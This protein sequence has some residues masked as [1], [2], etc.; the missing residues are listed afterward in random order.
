MIPED[1]SDGL[2][3]QGPVSSIA[4]YTTYVN[5][6]Q[7]L[8][9]KREVLCYDVSCWTTYITHFVGQTRPYEGG[10]PSLTKLL[11]KYDLNTPALL[12]D[13]DLLESNI[14][15][16]ADFF[17]TV[18]PEL[19]PHMKTHKIPIISHMQIDAGAIGIT[20]QKLEEAAVFAQSGIKN[21][22]V[23]NQIANEQKIRRFIGLCRWADITVGVDDLG[24]AKQISEG[25]LA[26]GV[27]AKVAVEVSML[28]CGFAPGVPTL[29]FVKEL[30]R[31]EG[32][33]FRGLWCHEAGDPS[34]HREWAKRRDAH[35]KGLQSFLE[36][37]SL[38]ESEGIPVSMCSG[39]YTATYDMTPTYQGITDVQ[40]GS[41]VFMDWPYREMEGLEKFKQALTVLTT[42]ISIPSHQKDQAYTDCGMKNMAPERTD[43]YRDF[44]LPKVKGEL[45]QH[46]DVVHFSEEHGHLKGSVG[47][48]NVGDKIEFVP[49]HCCTTTARYDVAHV[50]SGEKVVDCWPIVARGSHE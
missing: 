45:G 29:K 41:Y 5:P 11:S 17:K 50:V 37:K 46:L 34:A 7:L 27:T 47:K 39:G 33:E 3:S 21:I 15:M 18:Q 24:A 19:R 8:L 9:D 43:K 25:A 1:G 30:A 6:N 14:R 48:L 40:A 12:I 49:P 38:I 16:M 20:C 2:F 42:V 44:A 4:Q 23:A 10:Y 13:I 35:A 31:L 22:L 26:A 28:R 36:T 32:L